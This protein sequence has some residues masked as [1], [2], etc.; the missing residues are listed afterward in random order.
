MGTNVG[1][2]DLDRTVY[3]RRSA[4]DRKQAKL[5]A[6]TKTPPSSDGDGMTEGN[7]NNV[8][9]STTP[10]PPTD[11]VLAKA[12]TVPA[13]SNGLIRFEEDEGNAEA[14]DTQESSQEDIFG[15]GCFVTGAWSDEDV[16]ETATPRQLI[17]RRSLGRRPIRGSGRTYTSG[18]GSIS[19]H[20]RGSHGGSV[21]NRSSRFMAESEEAQGGAGTPPCGTTSDEYP[22]SSSQRSTLDS[23]RES[24]GGVSHRHQHHK[25]A[26][27]TSSDEGGFDDDDVTTEVASSMTPRQSASF[28]T[29]V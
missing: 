24:V 1:G 11:Q 10:P 25:I 21:R 18:S 5:A 20:S 26:L 13:A 16:E 27:T 17:K 28:T 4:R 14:D 22:C 12:A 7:N 8:D 2:G 9:S 29:N 3:N 15:G 19:R 6:A 23:N